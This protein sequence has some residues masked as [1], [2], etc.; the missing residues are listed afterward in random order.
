MEPKLGSVEGA[1][2]VETNYENLIYPRV[3]TSKAIP[4]MYRENM[5]ENNIRGMGKFKGNLKNFDIYIYLDPT[6]FILVNTLRILGIIL[7]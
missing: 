6:I 7:F 2:A 5:S 3:S 1:E 4:S